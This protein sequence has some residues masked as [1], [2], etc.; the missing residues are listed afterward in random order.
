MIDLFQP[1][2]PMKAQA[3]MVK[4]MDAYPPVRRGRQFVG[5]PKPKK[6]YRRTP[7]QHREK[8]RRYAEKHG[9]EVINA[10]EREAY[11]RRKAAAALNAQDGHNER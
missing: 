11:R 2:A 1:R 9:R 5:P 4:L 10:R 6:P 7:E 3:R 8:A